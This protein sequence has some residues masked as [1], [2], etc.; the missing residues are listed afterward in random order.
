MKKLYNLIALIFLTLISCS[1]DDHNNNPAAP[2]AS[3]T[4]TV[5]GVTTIVNNAYIV[6]PYTGTDPQYDNRRFYIVLTDGTVTI[7]N[8]EFVYADNIHNSI[9]F[10]LYTSADHLSSVQNTTYNLY[11]PGT[12]L[13]ENAFIDHTSI[14]NNVVIQNGNFISAEDLDSDDMNS[15]HLTLNVINGVYTFSFAFENDGNLV[16]GSFTG[17]PTTL[18]YQY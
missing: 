18:N 10:N 12:G 1:H 6:L 15:G 5:N 13:N 16:S 8:N 9:D 14:D 17:T 7:A 3:G 4:L 11:I 2:V